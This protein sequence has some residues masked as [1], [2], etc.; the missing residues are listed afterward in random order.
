ML[1]RIF[2]N[3]SDIKHK[4]MDGGTDKILFL[5]PHPNFIYY[6]WRYLIAMHRF[7]M[8]LP[9]YFSL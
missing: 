1:I 9:V 6:V 2:I 3:T 4:Q 5:F 8:A 7:P